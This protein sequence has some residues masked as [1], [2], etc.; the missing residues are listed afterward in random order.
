MA[1]SNWQRFFDAHAPMYMNNPFTENTVAEIAFLVEELNLPPGGAILDV[2]CGTGRHSI[3]LARQGYRVTGVD[4]SR[5]MLNEADKAAKQCHVEVEWVHADATEYVRERAFDAAICLCEGAFGLIDLDAD[6]FEQPLAILRNVHAS[7]K[8]QGKSVFTVLNACK[9]IRRYADDDVACG[10]FDPIHLVETHE[11][12]PETGREGTGLRLRERS[13]VPTELVLMFRQTGLEV[14][15]V[16]GGT[17]GNW[18]RRTLDLD[19]YEI[20]VI[21]KKPGA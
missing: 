9:P 12:D 2:G 19:E 21:A 16:Y 1:D 18:G 11:M 4:L 14:L 6:P 17:A 15:H 7:L 3:E 13:F 20:M 8:P 5:G 10:R